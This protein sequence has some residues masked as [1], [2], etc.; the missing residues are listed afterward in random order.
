MDENNDFEEYDDPPPYQEPSA[1]DPSVLRQALCKL[2]LLG[3]DP[4]LRM[5]AFNLAIVDPFLMEAVSE[6][7]G[8]SL[9]TRFL[10]FR[11]CKIHSGI[12][13]VRP[14]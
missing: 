11:G 5:Q 3:D 1:I 4:Y 2:N 8:L 7:I 10:S 12:S 14:R 9:L 13:T 6:Q